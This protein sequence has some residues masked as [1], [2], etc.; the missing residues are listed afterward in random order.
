MRALFRSLVEARETH[1]VSAK[2]SDWLR[3]F[4]GALALSI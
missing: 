2:S 1:Q 4:L 3:L